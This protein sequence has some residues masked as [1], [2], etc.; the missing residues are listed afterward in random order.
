MQLRLYSGEK[1]TA[2]EEV[3]PGQLCAVTG[4]S[5]TFAGQGLGAGPAGDPPVTEPVM[6]YRVALPKNCDPV[7]ALQKLR[8]LEE[9]DPQLHVLWDN[10]TI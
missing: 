3:F 5:G 10:N 8:Q 6:T 7:Q 2:P 9:E 4:L 1:Y